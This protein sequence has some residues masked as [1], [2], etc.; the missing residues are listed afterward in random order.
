MGITRNMNSIILVNKDQGKYFSSAWWSVLNQTKKFDQVIIVDDGSKES[1]VQLIQSCIANQST[2]DI[3]LISDQQNLGLSAR[4]NQALELV[5]SDWF[6]IL[7]ADDQLIPTANEILSKSIDESVNVVWG[8]LDLI[9]E[10]GSELN[11]SRPRDTWQGPVALRYI[12]PRYPFKDLLRYNNFIPGGMTLIRTA[13]VRSAS[14]WDPEL[15]TEDLDLWLRIGKTSRFKYVNESVGKYRIVAGSKSRRDSHK[16]LDNSKL[17]S[18]QTG[19]DASTD[20]NIAYLAAM[21]WAFTVFRTKRIPA[22]SLT[23]MAKIIGIPTWYLWTQL[24]RAIV[25]PIVGAIFARVKR[26]T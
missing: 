2:Y 24:P 19:V 4:L 20:R 12:E 26:L 8:N 22:M 3:E 10:D 14:A 16:L 5:R 7:A 9:Q 13:V 17:L 25:I 1:D 6:M 18:K 23:E 15:T 11:L 21:R